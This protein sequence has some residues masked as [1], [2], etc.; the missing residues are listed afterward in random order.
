LDL[1]LVPS[2]RSEIVAVPLLNA[3]RLD[4]SKPVYRTHSSC[5]SAILAMLWPAIT[6]LWYAFLQPGKYKLGMVICPT[7]F[8]QLG[9]LFVV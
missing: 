4:T 6:Y 9:H 7:K 5:L 1:L 2:A 3:K 8:S